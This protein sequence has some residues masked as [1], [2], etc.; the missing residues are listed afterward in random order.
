MTHDGQSGWA[1]GMYAAEKC[2]LQ[3]GG[4]VMSTMPALSYLVDAYLA[5]Y[6]SVSFR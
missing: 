6:A 2:V 3:L 1:C 5:K 4:H